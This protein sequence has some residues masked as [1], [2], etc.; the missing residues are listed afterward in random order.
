MEN[1]EAI[2]ALKDALKD[3][4]FTDQD[5]LF[6]ASFD[7]MKLSFM[8]QAVIRPILSD[9]VGVVLK[10]AN[11]YDIPV[12]TRGAGSTLT[13]SATPVK[14]GWVLDLT[15][16]NSIEIDELGKFAYVGAG[17]ITG[18]IQQ[19][20]E[21]VNLF[22]ADRKSTRLNSSHIQKSRMPSSA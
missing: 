9:D 8:P 1:I 15:R 16:L 10:L 2:S 5:S 18:D 13:G 4:V 20:A 11:Q 12:T 22:Y 7:A 17:A 6:R 21:A 14:G 19:R 3:C